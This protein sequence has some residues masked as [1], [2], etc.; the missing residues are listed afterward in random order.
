MYV[1]L[2]PTLLFSMDFRF[3]PYPEIRNFVCY[4]KCLLAFFSRLTSYKPEQAE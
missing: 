3:P 4:Q 2:V 1:W